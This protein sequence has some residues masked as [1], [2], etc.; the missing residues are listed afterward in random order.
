[1]EF[2]Q[3]RWLSEVC[4][5][6]VF[7]VSGPD[8]SSAE[9]SAHCSQ[10]A[11]A[12]YFSKRPTNE[13]DAVRKLTSVGVYIVDTAVTLTRLSAEHPLSSGQ[14]DIEVSLAEPKIDGDSIRAIAE[15]SFVY[16]RF[17]L[18][19]AIQPELANRIKRAWIESYLT[20]QR[21]ECLW[22]AKVDS[23]VAGFLAV[24]TVD[25]GEPRARSIDLIAVGVSFQRRGVG[26]VLVERFI[27]EGGK[28]IRRLLVGTQA[29]NTPS[30][31]LYEQTGFCVD[32]TQY[33]LHMHVRSG[34]PYTEVNDGNR[35]D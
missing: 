11:D 21:G 9:F 17:H 5:R 14:P 23:V 34:K 19:P 4:G 13:V 12:F 7:Q 25:D 30:I 15:S 6:P 33:V 31:R 8:V 2:N 22:V 18:D 28:K 10:Q 35:F 32:R 16:S 26:R 27:D 20:R 29:A 24:T 1:M 3:D